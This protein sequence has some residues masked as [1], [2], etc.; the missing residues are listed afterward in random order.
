MTWH[1]SR[2]PTNLPAN[3]DCGP[4]DCGQV[5]RE[6]SAQTS[7]PKPSVRDV[8]GPRGWREPATAF[9]WLVAVLLELAVAG[10][11]PVPLTVPVD[12]R[13]N[14][15]LPPE[16]RVERAWIV[17]TLIG[18]GEAGSGGDGGP[19]LHAQLHYPRGLALDGAGNLYVVDSFNSRVRR[20]DADGVITTVAGTGARGY[21][22]D[23]GAAT[24]ARLSAPAG[25]AVDAVGN[26]Y[27]A[28]AL[29]ARIRKI[30]TNGVITTLA[31]TGQRGYGG[32]GGP[33]ARALLYEP[34]GVAADTVGN[35]Y[36]ADALGSRI[37]R[38]DADG[39]ITTIGGTGVQGFGGDDG[40]ATQ[41]RLNGPLGVAVGALGSVYVADA[42]N[43]RLRRID[44]DGTAATL[45]GTGVWGDSGDGGPAAKARMR[46]PSAVAVDRTGN[47]YVADTRSHRVR[48]IDTDGV[49]TTIAGTGEHGDGGDGTPGDAIGLARPREM[50]VNAEGNVYLS[51]TGNHR[52]LVMRPL[53]RVFVP[54]GTSS[55]ALEVSAGGALSLNGQPLVQGSDVTAE[56]G[57]IH[58]LRIG[59][60]GFLAGS[61]R[62]ELRVPVNAA[63]EPQLPPNFPG[64][65]SRVIVTVAGTGTEGYGGDGGP[66]ERAQLR[67]PFHLAADAIG[68]IYV[69]DEIN[70]AV[71]R[72]DG[73]GVISTIA[74]T[75]M[76]G[77]GG[78][79]GPAVAALLSSPTGVAVDSVGNVYVTDTGNHRVRKIDADGVITTVAGTGMQGHGGDGGLATEAQLAGPTGVAVDSAGNLYIADKRNDRLRRVGVNGGIMTIAGTG[80]RGDGGDGGPATNAE[81][82]G[83]AGVAVDSVGN[84]YVTDSD[85]HRVRK[86]DADGVI[87]TVAGTGEPGDGGDGGLAREAQ[88][89][90]PRQVAVDSADDL[91]I[92]DASNDRVR[93]V[94]AD[95]VITTVA[96]I[97]GDGDGGP[98][99]QVRLRHPIGIAV[100]AAG[101]WFV[102]EHHGHRVRQIKHEVRLRLG[103]SGVTLGVAKGGVLTWNGE[104]LVVDAEVMS[105]DG[106]VYTLA[107]G[108]DGII[109][110]EFVPRE[111]SVALP[112]GTSV[113]LT[114]NE[115]GTWRA[116]GRVVKHGY[117]HISG[118]SEYVLEL[119]DGRWALAPYV[120]RTIAGTTDIPEGVNAN[121]AVVRQPCGVAVDN[122][123]NVYVTATHRVRKI[124]VSGTIYTVA[125]TGMPGYGGDGGPASQ[126][127]LGN[128]SCHLAA[129]ALGNVYVADA[130]NQRVR[131]ID[132][133]GVVTTIAGT[134][135]QGN[136]GDGGPAI[137]AQLSGPFGMAV[138]ALGN[139]YVAET[140]NPRVREIDASGVITT[141]AGTGKRGDSGDGGPATQAQLW[142]PIQ[143]AADMLGN[144][145][146]VD[147]ASHRVRKVDSSGV[148]T[149]IAGTGEPG[150]SG[151]GGP[152]TQAQLTW[153]TGVAVDA[154]GNVYVAD[155][156]NHRVRKIDAG[157]V[158][159]TVAGTGEGGDAGDGGPAT[160]AQ[161]TWPT[162]V[163]VDALGNLYVTDRASH[164]V[165]KVDSSGMIDGF[166]GTGRP[167]SDYV[168]RRAIHADLHRPR[169]LS[170]DSFGNTYFT[171]FR[172]R[173][174]KLDT[175]GFVSAFAGSTSR[176]HS[177]D[178]GPASQATLT[179]PAHLATDAEGNVFVVDQRRVR[180]IDT[181]GVITTFAGTGERGYSGDGG[182]ATAAK[183]HTPTGLVA[184]SAGN[185]YLADADPKTGEHVVRRI[186]PTG[187]ITKIAGRKATGGFGMALATDGAGN[188]YAAL[189]GWREAPEVLKVDAAGQVTVLTSLEGFGQ[190]A[191]IAADPEGNVFVGTQR[192]ILRLDPRG[193]ISVLAGNSAESGIGG[194]GGPARDSLLSTGGIALDSVG[195]LWFADPT[196]RSIRML[197]R[198]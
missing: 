62:P 91:Y 61:Y 35:I 44:A 67:R 128:E 179:Y 144:V 16:Y 120:T 9:A 123:G 166:A 46:T 25:V 157:G 133:S 174:W 19:A 79:G 141:I 149:T 173:I 172:H 197:E 30:D 93:K 142:W 185:V 40:P 51:D 49:I 7:N 11:T 189:T 107:M 137:L 86:I 73:N 161:L 92:A 45:A 167:T 160:Q 75:G 95:G 154:L 163:A 145:Y 135:Q 155:Q 195:N 90:D 50:T 112:N 186:D 57:S 59:R 80:E 84:V 65:Y 192:Q 97:G 176:G 15:D 60:G 87:T 126:A 122:S 116:G 55:A 72:V 66:A 39:V 32:D 27:V 171:D 188:L 110:A 8:A 74:G 125:G 147:L 152:A 89:S 6:P 119:I 63:G 77:Y 169:Y 4:H 146:V 3:R 134:G 83:P 47:L 180:R 198:Q 136:A 23:G 150:V 56:D 20:V 130:G 81:F 68:N 115:A 33:A 24:Q 13:G 129:D 184:D 190:G 100:D 22:G 71:R 138:D 148:I 38:I 196:A 105:W 99:T 113:K 26:I 151:D 162:G 58:T 131:K 103:P 28:D 78:D 36:V 21:G 168:R 69:A 88:L 37:R 153:P 29:N 102:A 111:Q 70:H 1:K 5:W 187:I 101:N 96:G 191:T 124:D 43:S 175:A 31:G 108:S 121:S 158:I 85:N 17:D 118:G 127:R 104:P 76:Q 193:K 156:G 98:P 82:N 94:G 14:P 170:I 178:G 159:T 139:V 18:T 42:G 194:D 177:G 10:A 53:V 64:E 117:R 48:R 182:P 140:G 114:N 54:L 12:S 132:G 164:R 165:R 34:V 181:Q 52:V 41:A 2:I 106:D 143:V 183:L 109:E